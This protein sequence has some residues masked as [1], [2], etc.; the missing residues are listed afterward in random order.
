MPETKVITDTELVKQIKTSNLDERQKA[1]LADL[2]SEMTAEERNELLGLIYESNELAREKYKKLS[3]LNEEY[4]RKM[5]EVAH[6]QSEYAR[7]E[8]EKFDKNISAG[9]LKTVEAQIAG[10]QTKSKAVSKRVELAKG[11]K[12]TLRNVMMTIFLLI[13]IATGVLFGLSYL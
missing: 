2:V 9:E 5:G 8:F 7:Q 6:E 1:E 12:H 4:K 11:K 10:I 3:V 13:L